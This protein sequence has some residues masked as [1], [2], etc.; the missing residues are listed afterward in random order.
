M[1]RVREEG[2]RRGRRDKKETERVN[3]GI[4][5]NTDRWTRR[6]IEKDR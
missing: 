3:E 5:A 4:R 1:E 2:E 6:W